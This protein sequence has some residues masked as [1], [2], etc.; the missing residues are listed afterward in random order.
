MII[1]VGII[2]G[3]LF[4][5]FAFRIGFYETWILLLN[6]VISAY[7]AIFL[8]LMLIDMETF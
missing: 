4:A 3:L 7:L 6:L 8:G 2:I 5:F 1:G